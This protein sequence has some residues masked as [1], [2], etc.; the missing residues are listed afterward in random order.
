MKII[1]NLIL[2]KQYIIK[3]IALLLL[4]LIG[5]LIADILLKYNNNTTCIWNNLFQ[6]ECWGCGITR[7]FHAFCHLDFKSAYNY[8]NKIFIIIPILIYIW[9]NEIMKFLKQIDIDKN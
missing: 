6:I 4:P 5:Y 2:N 3:L 8:N 1:N 9:I 7:A